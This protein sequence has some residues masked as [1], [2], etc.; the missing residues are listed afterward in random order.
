[1]PSDGLHEDELGEAQANRSAAR[2]ILLGL[3][4]R[5]V[6]QAVQTI[7]RRA[8]NA[9]HASNDQEGWQRHD[10]RIERALIA[11]QEPAH[12]AGLRS[13]RAPARDDER[14]QARGDAVHETD[15]SLHVRLRRLVGIHP[16]PVG[17]AASDD[18]H[19]PGVEPHECVLSLVK[20]RP[21]RAS[22]DDVIRNDV[23]GAEGQPTS[24]R[25]TPRHSRRLAR[26]GELAEEENGPGQPHGLK[27]VRQGIGPGW[28]VWTNGQGCRT[29][30]HGASQAGVLLSF[31]CSNGNRKRRIT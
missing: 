24:E 12:N 11:G 20:A 28:R 4:E 30:G 8:V 6:D 15:G 13:A 29:V 2:L 9:A 14:E 16:E 3:L 23:V 18:Q 19:I 22:R 1:M 5:Q 10:E 7:P 27:H 25:F 21:K 31:A 17:V 26:S